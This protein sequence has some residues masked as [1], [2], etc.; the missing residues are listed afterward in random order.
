MRFGNESDGQHLTVKVFQG[1]GLGS[2]V[3]ETPQLRVEARCRLFDGREQLGDEIL[4]RYVPAE[5][6]KRGIDPWVGKRIARRQFR[7]VDY[8]SDARRNANN[9]S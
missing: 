5:P 4:E 8:R 6:L 1:M 2:L 3:L 9:S 7:A